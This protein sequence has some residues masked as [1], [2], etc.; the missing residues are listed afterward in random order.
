[1][2]GGLQAITGDVQLPD[3]A[4][5]DQAVD[6]GRRRHGILEDLLPLRKRQVA[7]QQDAATLVA[8]GQQRE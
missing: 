7:R 3:H 1:M 8:F 6:R 4:V 2:L 5:M